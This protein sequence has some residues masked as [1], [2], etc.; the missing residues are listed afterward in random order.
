MPQVPYQPFPTAQPS[1]QGTPRVRVGTSIEAFGGGVAQALGQLGQTVGHAGDE[2]FSRAIALQ[3]LNNET[4]AKEADAQYM[5]AAGEL[6][7]RY[8]ALEGKA[9][10]DAYPQYQK[11]LNETRV[12]FRQGLS[13]AMAQRMYDSSSLSTMSRSIFNGAGHAASQQK[14]WVIGTADSKMKLDAQ[15][16]E[17]NPRDEVGQ[18]RKLRAIDGNVDTIAAAKG[19]GNEQTEYAKKLQKSKLLSA[20]IIGLSKEAPLEA[21]ERLDKVKTELDQDDYDRAKAR[22]D[23]NTRNQGARIISDQVTG[24][25]KADPSS[26]RKTLQDLLK[27]SDELIAKHGI[28]DPI[29]ID[30]VHRRVRQNYYS[31]KRDD[32]DARKDDLMFVQGKAAGVDGGPK[33]TN[34]DALFAADPMMQ[35]RYAR[36]NPKEQIGVQK[37]LEQNAKG[38]VLDTPESR[39]AYHTYL[40]MAQNQPQEFGNVNV[41]GLPIPHRWQ[42]QLWDLQVKQWKNPGDNPQVRRAFTTLMPMLPNEVKQPGDTRNAFTGALQEA[43]MDYQAENQ[44]MPNRD[45]I[46]KMGRTLLTTIPKT[47][48]F[49]DDRVFEY[50]PKSEELKAA[51]EDYPFSTDEE[52]AARVRQ[53]RFNEL[54]QKFYGKKQ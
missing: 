49:S 25:L 7:A 9:A 15:E 46:Q 26:D 4:E 32:A 45:E 41:W 12:K 24:Y 35:P 8:S 29:A 40:G 1:E 14:A 47:G 44:K 19:W 52:L 50:T 43:L 10:V 5:I 36:L 28:E 18:Q 22:V 11:D 53:A 30:E 34:L 16:V 13:S 2:L 48:W 21:Q 17:D 51:K 54:Y 3:Q 38:D 27:D 42:K 39:Q 23:I 20:G 6:H 33:P 31:I 37:M